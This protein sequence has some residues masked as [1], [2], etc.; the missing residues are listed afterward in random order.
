MVA[1][2]CQ[3]Q[4]KITGKSSKAHRVVLQL[5]AGARCPAAHP[6]VLFAG[7][8]V[9]DEVG[10]GPVGHDL[11]AAYTRKEIVGFPSFSPRPFQ[12]RFQ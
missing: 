7:V 1:Y 8:D 10:N 12:A 3:W 2:G 9:E 6:G 4:T 11:V 5:H